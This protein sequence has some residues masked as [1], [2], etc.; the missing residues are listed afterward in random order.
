MERSIKLYRLLHHHITDDY[1]QQIYIGLFS[2]I[3]LAEEAIDA[4]I[5]QPGFNKHPRSSFI[6]KPYIVDEYSWKKG[7]V[8]IDDEDIEIV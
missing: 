1:P 5:M 3:Y 8:K 2:D 6:I 7:F 4:L